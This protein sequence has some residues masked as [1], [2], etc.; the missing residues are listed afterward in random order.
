R[1]GYLALDHT[2]P[3]WWQPATALLCHGD[4]AHLMGNMFNLLIFGK[5]TEEDMGGIGM[6]LSFLLCGVVS[7][8][9]SLIVMPRDC[10]SVGASGAVFGLYSITVLG[11][12]ILL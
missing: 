6:L 1:L 12:V 5:M 2:S 9:A 3:K 7:N 11:K 10:V 4:R 8:M